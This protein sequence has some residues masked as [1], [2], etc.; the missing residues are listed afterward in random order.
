MQVFER[1]IYRRLGGDDGYGRWAVQF[2]LSRGQ[3]ITYL[4]QGM[5]LIEKHRELD[6]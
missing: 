1:V 6:K 3:R 4:R 5:Q 2:L